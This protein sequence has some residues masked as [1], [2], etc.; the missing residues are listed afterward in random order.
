V[1]FW[2]PWGLDLSGGG[3]VVGVDQSEAFERKTPYN[4][5][6]KEET[7][8]QIPFA[9]SDNPPKNAK[10]GHPGS[11]IVWPA[12]KTSGLQTDTPFSL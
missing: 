11:R 3:H 10:T 9:E 2:S 1:S 12:L 7:E 4:Q 6:L 5:G 8:S